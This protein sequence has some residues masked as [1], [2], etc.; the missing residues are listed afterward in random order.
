MLIFAENLCAREEMRFSCALKHTRRPVEISLRTEDV[1]E[2]AHVVFLLSRP[3]DAEPIYESHAYIPGGDQR[4]RVPPAWF[5][6]VELCVR[7]DIPAG[8]S[9]QILSL[10]ADYGEKAPDWEGGLRFNAHLGLWGMAPNNTMPAFE[11]AALCGFP[12]CIVVPKLTAEGELVC[13]HDDTLTRYSRDTEGNPPEDTRKIWEMTLPE[14][15]SWDYGLYK[16]PAWRGTGIPRLRDFFDL[17]RDSGMRP[18]FSTHPGLPVEKWREVREMLTERGLLS[19]FHIKSF[20]LDVLECAWSVFG[21]DIDGYT[22][23]NRRWEPERLAAYA[24]SAI[25]FSACRCGMEV[26][27]DHYTPEIAREILDTGLF[28]AAWS[29]KRRSA[30]EYRRIISWGI[31]EFTEDYHCSFEEN[32]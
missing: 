23:D 21:S 10:F 6:G 8:G 24:A 30:E 22:Y 11:L 2:G 9:L 18:K 32:M 20:D 5:D 1:C 31:T 14:L 29:I 16:H 15:D 12:A 3:G 19:R 25:D 28:A 7:F 26:R 13:I 27:F 4:F 17:C